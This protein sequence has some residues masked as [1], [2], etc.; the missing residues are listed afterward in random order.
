MNYKIVALALFAILIGCAMSAEDWHNHG[1]HHATEPP[2]APPTAAAAHHSSTPAPT[3]H[4]SHQATS[5]PTA[6]PTHAASHT[7]A[8]THAP[9]AAPTHAASHTAAP[10]HAPTAAP[11]HAASHTA[12]PTQKASSSGSSTT[13]LCGITSTSSEPVQILVPLYVYPGSDWDTVA[14]AAESG[15]KIIAIINPNSG[16]DTSGPDS[17]YNTYMSKLTA[18]GV[19]MIGYVHTSYG[20]RSTSDVYADIDTYASLYPG[21]KGIFID[22]ASPSSSEISYYQ[23]VYDQITGHSGYTNVILNPGTQPDQG[24]LAVSTSIVIFED[25]ASNFQNNFASWVT[26]APSAAEKSGYKY[27]FSGIAYAASS[28]S[29]S[30]LVDS[31][32]GSGMGLVY[33]T[34][35]AA[36]GSTYNTL[37]SYFSSEAST[38]EA[39]N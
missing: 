31:M 20:D 36:G 21:L 17:S 23:G 22:E 38:V 34:D 16:P 10:T 3:E 33:V 12:A 18:A 35:G 14:T 32:V 27:R 2:T 29:L 39:L 24:Y 26:C 6:A 9:T 37:A 28:G 11:T 25:A 13:S 30:S 4:S 7:A 19:D 1:G 15:V 8:P 5:Q